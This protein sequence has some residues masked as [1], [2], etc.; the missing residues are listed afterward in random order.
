MAEKKP[1]PGTAI[2]G[3]KPG[4]LLREAREKR[5]LTP[6]EIAMQLNLRTDTIIALENDDYE[7]LPVAA[8]VRGYMR[9]YARIVGLDANTLIRLYEA[10]DIAPP[11]IIPDVKKHTQA[12][13]R[14]K[15]VKAVT[16]LVTFGLALLLLAWLQ[17][18]YVVDPQDKA[19]S[20]AGGAGQYGGSL[21]YP[22]KIVIHPDTPFLEKE[23]PSATA[24]PEGL[25]LYDEKSGVS[26]EITGAMD[27]PGA[28]EEE[29]EPL[30]G[31]VA[32]PAGDGGM[33]DGEDRVSFLIKKESWI[34]V[35]DS[36]NNKMFK[37]LARPGAEIRL[38]GIAPFSVLLGFS[39]GVE[40]TFNGKKFDPEPFSTAGV[41][42]FRLG[43]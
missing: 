3:P 38:S 41:A 32:H 20:D 33:P 36:G 22:I 15:P 9:S 10:E 6:A 13:S 42:R 29:A 28:P 26:G 7:K 4:K 39:P 5:E 16:Y 27:S 12:S 30:P 19:L 24:P 2:P 17:S 31:A 35:Y 21:N 34:E 37:D 1:K 18:H 43:E 8:Y 40:V 25:A 11:E 14:D 23:T